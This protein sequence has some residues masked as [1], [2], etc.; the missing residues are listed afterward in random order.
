MSNNTVND[1]PID[2]KSTL[3]PRKRAKTQE[4]KEQ[5]RIERI[6]RNRRAAHQSREKKRLH[7]LYLERKC[8]LLER[9]VS[10]VNLMELSKSDAILKELVIEYEDILGSNSNSDTPVSNSNTPPAIVEPE[11]LS[12]ITSVES[13]SPSQFKLKTEFA[14][15]YI[16]EEPTFK[17][18]IPAHDLQNDESKTSQQD[19]WNLLLT[20]DN[21]QEQYQQTVVSMD[22]TD[23]SAELDYWRNPAVIAR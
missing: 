3:P 13:N 9:I 4:E 20:N 17:Q 5:R 14:Y 8:S 10:K 11:S 7:L 19:N 18:F 15:D 12:P 6:L 16:L 1:I 22:M 23:N 2:F 21:D